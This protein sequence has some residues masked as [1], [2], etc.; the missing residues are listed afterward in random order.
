MTGTSSRRV[1]LRNAAVAVLVYV[2]VGL[3]MALVVRH[4]A[5]FDEP[6]GLDASLGSFNAFLQETSGRWVTTDVQ[7]D[8]ASAAALVHREDPYQV[9]AVLFDRYGIPSWGVAVANPHPPTTVAMMIPFALISYKDALTAWSVLMVF[10]IIWTIQLMG[11]RVAYAAPLGLAICAIWPGAYAIGNV[12]PV[13]GLGI[14]LA[15]RF[16]DHPLLA[17]AGLTLAAAPKASGLILLVPFVL[18]LRWKP[19][20]WTAGF[21][22]A[23]ALLPLA[24]YPATWSRYLDVGVTSITLNAAR[25]DNAAVLN[26]AAKVGLPSW[27]AIGGIIAVAVAAALLIRDSFWPTVW[28]IVALLPIAWMYSLVTLI[29]LFCVAVRR[30]NPWGVG[31]VV[32]GTAL[33]VGSP[34]LGMMPTKILPLIVLA[35]FVALLQVRENAFWP[36]RQDIAGMLRRFRR[37]TQGVEPAGTQ[38]AAGQRIASV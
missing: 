18:T 10:A 31:A 27:L 38:V 24:F 34:P 2:S 33:A 6:A 3:I 28:L 37:R 15:Y 29:P 13:I 25:D 36:D 17:A 22:G 16:R 4:V 14:A 1:N 7:L 20:L 21:M 8:F 35:A 9:S 32:I 19:V 12:A 30:P 5:L 26:L 11:V 23:L